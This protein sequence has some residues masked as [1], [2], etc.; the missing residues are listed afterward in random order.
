M[1]NARCLHCG[2]VLSFK[3]SWC[4]GAFAENNITE[5][6]AHGF[7]MSG[8]GGKWYRNGESGKVTNCGIGLLK[9]LAEI[10]SSSQSSSSYY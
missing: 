10:H 7:L 4:D 5:G 3:A 6:D 1:G 8:P 9:F 2:P